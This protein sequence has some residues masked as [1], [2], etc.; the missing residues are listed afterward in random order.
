MRDLAED[1]NS[2]LDQSHVTHHKE[3]ATPEEFASFKEDLVKRYSSPI[4]E[5]SIPE[6]CRNLP[7]NHWIDIQTNDVSISEQG[8]LTFVEEDPKA[9][10]G[11]TIRMPSTHHEWAIQNYS[12]RNFS[13]VHLYV[14]A[15]VEAVDSEELPEGGLFQIGVYNQRERK[16]QIE[17]KI[18]TR[19]D[20]KGTD[21]SIIDL[22]EFPC[23][24]DCS[25][26]I[27]PIKRTE[28]P[29]NIFVDRIVLTF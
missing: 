11:E 25:L 3:S 6:I 14:S 12:L 16:D 13:N 21:Y 1:F 24:P 9:S 28:D 27:A 15:R 5:V 26:W 22:G 10:D 23:N 29:V 20:L 18:V 4:E 7:S 19:S 2:R 8:T 17:T